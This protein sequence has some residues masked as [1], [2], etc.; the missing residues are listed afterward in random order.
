[1]T[2]RCWEG[3]LM[4]YVHEIDTL[5]QEVSLVIGKSI[6]RDKYEIIDKGLP[7]VPPTRLPAEKMAV[8]IVLARR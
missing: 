4:D 6:S 3:E 2:S 7:H 5:I 8:Y 1:M